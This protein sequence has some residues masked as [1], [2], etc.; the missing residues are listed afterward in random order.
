[1]SRDKGVHTNFDS[2]ERDLEYIKNFRLMDDDFMAK[3]F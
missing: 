3:F 2:S 1:M